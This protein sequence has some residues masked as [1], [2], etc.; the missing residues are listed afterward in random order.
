[1]DYKIFWSE[2]AIKN[3]DNI[4]DYLIDKW[5]DREVS[6]FKKKLS[7]Q[8]ELIIRNPFIFPVSEYQPNLRKAVLSRQTT[9][10]YEV[11]G[12]N[13]KLVYL[14]VNKMNINKIK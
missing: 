9:M 3:L 6:N 4:L 2:E 11:K 7:K 5:S 10:F 13:I 8:I 14:F 1:M 12:Q